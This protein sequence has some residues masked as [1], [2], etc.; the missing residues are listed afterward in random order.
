MSISGGTVRL[1]V[2]YCCGIESCSASVT[3][4]LP[5][6]ATI[7]VL[8]CRRSPVARQRRECFVEALHRRGGDAGADL[9]DAGLAGARSRC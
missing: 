9:A 6:K 7:A 4:A 5:P 1:T 2:S 3:S 8:T